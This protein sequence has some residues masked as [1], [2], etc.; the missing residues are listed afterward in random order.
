MRRRVV[1]TGMGTLNPL[2]HD[3]DTFWAGVVA[4]RSGIGP[5]TAYDASEQAVR[6]AGEVKGF[7][8]TRVLGLKEARR[9]D[10]FSQLIVA[11]ADQAIA[12]AGLVFAGGNG[13][14]R[15][16]GVIVGTGIGGVGTLLD[17]Y[18]T[19]RTRGPRRVSA[20]MAPMMMPNA[21]AG[22]IAIKYGL[23]GISL[24][25]ASAC[26]TG[27]NAL[28]E[29]AERIRW[30][31]AEVMICGGG[32]SVMHPLTLAAFSNMR[33]VSHRNDEPERASRP[34][35][36][37]RDGF[38]MGEGAGILVVESL[39]HAQQ[40]GARIHAELAGYGV[41]SDAFHITAPDEE[42]E[43]AALSM[44]HALEDAGMQPEEIDYINAHGTSTPLNDVT[45]TRAI[46]KVFGRHAGRLQISST[47]S[48][49]GHLMGAAGAVEAIAC[50]KSLQTG[51]LHPTI[52]YETP[53][54]ECDL[55]YVPNQARESHPRTALSNSF[56][57]GGHNATLILRRW[58][59]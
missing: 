33:A 36:R 30:G 52:N 48:M 39:E 1:V 47:K 32:E 16:V 25:L 22:E 58:E 59:G 51:I 18:D 26:A 45:E 42:G 41:S 19:L 8:A 3:V 24:S 31:A 44:L 20:L 56:G 34:F 37:D 10:R 49:T 27:S 4:G 40:R 13:N 2:G 53:D 12:D 35:D 15:H 38:V 11:A 55:D 9:T 21:G 57:F 17:A 43:G 28:G 46:H 50:I 29:A 54:P 6:I 23:H 5:I 7:D 14:N